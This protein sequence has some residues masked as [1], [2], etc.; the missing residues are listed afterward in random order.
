[1]EETQ[2]HPVPIPQ[3]KSHRARRDKGTE[4]HARWRDSERQDTV[5]SQIMS[6]T[7]VQ[8]TFTTLEQRG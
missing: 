3:P 6:S 8:R 5:R 7:A 1:M 2:A 4:R